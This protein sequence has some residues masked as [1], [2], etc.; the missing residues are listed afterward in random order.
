MDVFLPP[1]SGSVAAASPSA[2]KPSG[3]CTQKMPCQPNSGRIPP[4]SVGP[5]AV[6]SADTVPSSPMAWP[7]R[8]SEAVSRIS[9]MAS[10]IRKAAPMPCNARA[11]ISNL[12]LGASADSSAAPVKTISPASSI[13]FSPCRSPNRPAITTERVSAAR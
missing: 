2:S 13:G 10:V 7:T 4:P 12:R 11:A 5:S 9:A 6:P 3:T 1:V 8:A